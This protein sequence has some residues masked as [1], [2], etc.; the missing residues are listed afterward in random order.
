MST[1]HAESFKNVE[2]FHFLLFIRDN[3]L[4][5]TGLRINGPRHQVAS[6]IVPKCQLDSHGGATPPSYAAQSQVHCV[7]VD[8]V[9]DLT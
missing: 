2:H 5:P 9:W 4:L 7:G 1:H 3:L 8:L 6:R